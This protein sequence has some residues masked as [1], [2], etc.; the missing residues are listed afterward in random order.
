MYKRRIFASSVFLFFTFLFTLTAFAQAT[1]VLRLTKVEEEAQK[2]TFN[3][4]LQEIEDVFAIELVIGFDPTVVTMV[5]DKLVAGECPV[6]EFPV[7]NSADNE[8]GTISYAVSQL[9]SEPCNGGVVASF[10]MQCNDS[11]TEAAEPEL[12]FEKHLIASSE[13]LAIEHSVE[14]ATMA[15]SG[16]TIAN[17]TDITIETATVTVIKATP[18]VTPI[19]EVTVVAESTSVASGEETPLVTPTPSVKEEEAPETLPLLITGLILAVTLIIVAVV[20][21]LR[22][23]GSSQTKQ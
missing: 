9:T 5:E 17:T 4:E 14:H 1:A 21:I 12:R 18:I 16:T 7:V 15:C 3:V 8:Q 23:K 20:A 11:L 2:T 19:S 22:I 10:T 13:G 6:D